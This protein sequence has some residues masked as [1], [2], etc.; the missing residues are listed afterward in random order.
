MNETPSMLTGLLIYF[1]GFI[2]ILF[3]IAGSYFLTDG[4]NTKGDKAN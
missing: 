1:A 4:W 2:T 3:V